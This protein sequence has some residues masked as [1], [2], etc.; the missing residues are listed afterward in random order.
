MKLRNVK[1]TIRTLLILI[2][3]L[4]NYDYF[5]MKKISN[6]ILL[7]LMVTLYCQGQTTISIKD[8]K[9]IWVSTMLYV[10][11]NYMPIPK[12]GNIA[13]FGFTESKGKL[14]Q[15]RY[16]GLYRMVK[17]RSKPKLLYYS[18]EGNKVLFYDSSDNPLSYHLEIDSFLPQISMTATIVETTN[19]SKV[20]MRF[21]Y[22]EK[23]KR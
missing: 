11:G 22:Y 17:E 13:S 15:S 2:S 16:T 12:D 20:K 19:K 6:V 14:N 18:L 5:T 1:I 8:L 21:L 4:A 23:D 9:G 10:D 3:K 7:A